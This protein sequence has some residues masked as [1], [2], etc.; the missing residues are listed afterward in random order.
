MCWSQAIATCRQT[1]IERGIIGLC[2]KKADGC[3]NP[4]EQWL[5]GM[6]G[7]G[8][9]SVCGEWLLVTGGPHWSTIVQVT[10][11]PIP[12]IAESDSVEKAMQ[13]AWVYWY[14]DI[15]PL[16]LLIPLN[17]GYMTWNCTGWRKAGRI[18]PWPHSPMRKRLICAQNRF[19]LN[20]AHR[21]RDSDLSL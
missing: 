14:W 17:S 19:K 8:E 2:C 18:C 12:T 20:W 15:P 4:V 6:D 11:S 7:K 9:G 3:G 10:S 5:T 1:C 21:F 16:Q 13:P